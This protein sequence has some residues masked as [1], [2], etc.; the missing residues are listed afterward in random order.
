MLFLNKRG[1]ATVF[2][3]IIL[4]VIIGACVLLTDSYIYIS[5]KRIIENSVSS[6]A[7]SALGTYSGFLKENYDLY[8]YCISDE[9]LKNIILGNLTNNLGDDRI[10]DFKIESI[11]TVK[12]KNFTKPEIMMKMIEAVAVDDVYKNL[13]DEFMERFDIISG[14]GSAAE[15]ITLKMKLDKSYQNIKNSMNSLNEVI[16]GGGDLEYCINLAGFGSDFVNAVEKFNEYRSEIVKVKTQIAELY[17]EIKSNPSEKAAV[18]DLLK[19]QL[20]QIRECAADV[21][22]SFI[23]DFILGLKQAN[24][25]A[26]KH[27]SDI[28]K[29]NNNMHLISNAISESISGI[30]DCPGYLKEILY[31]CAEL[32]S[33]VED[34]FI[35]QVFEEIKIEI[36]HNI[37]ILHNLEDVFCSVIEEDKDDITISA[38]E[39]SGYNS[40]IAFFYEDEIN[41][42][43]EDDKRSFFEEMGK[44]ILEKQMGR[45]IC[46]NENEILPSA[47][48]TKNSIEFNVTSTGESTESGEV[49]INELSESA[50]LKNLDF[51]K[52]LALDEYIIEHFSY[53]KEGNKSN[54]PEGFFANE[55]EYILWGNESQNKNNFYTKAAIM[56]TRF[57]LNAIHVY[58]DSNKTAKADA[59]AAATAG[60][61]TMGAGMPVMSNLIKIS[62]AIAEAGID[63]GK[64][65]NGES[66]AIIKTPAEWITDIGVGASG[67][68]SPGFLKMDYDDYL[69][70]YLLAVPA[71]KKVLR[72]M[73]IISLNAPPDFNIFN[74]F[75]EITVTAVVSYR[76]LSGERHEV[77]MSVTKSY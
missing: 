27:I 64:L 63:T 4:P 41:I 10:Y 67:I 51:A 56:S 34:S 49:K 69:R 9:A 31:K 18:I 39:L 62:W 53:G 28:V 13:V 30:D 52:A 29:E 20:G 40:G 46:I 19:E 37:S 57:A 72:M 76:S 33:D 77:E 2:M 17:E 54:M 5:G 35:E 15:I 3:G 6:S 71:D 1:S 70:L 38:E 47:F 22:N 11:D 60:W 32:V 42:G 66:I 73:D 8:A 23:E 45:D 58:T 26:I 68:P 43:K 24:N 48:S 55:T 65:W 21:Y 59:L 12:G 50:Q 7:Y 25:E 16:N 61:W 44:K 75:T 14:F 36:E 74:A